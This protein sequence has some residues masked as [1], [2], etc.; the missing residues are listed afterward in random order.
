LILGG[1][2]KG[3]DF[4]KL[5]KAISES[6][7]KAVILVGDEGE[8]IRKSLKE[9]SFSGKIVLGGNNMEEIVNQAYQTACPGDAIV[10][11]PACAS[12]DMFKSYKDRGEQFNKAVKLLKNE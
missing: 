4:S 5:A 10:L 9:V 7:V 8:K 2:S 3:A 1:S 12:F 6:N 11:S